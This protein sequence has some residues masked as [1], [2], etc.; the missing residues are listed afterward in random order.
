MNTLRGTMLLFQCVVSITLLSAISSRAHAAQIT[1]DALA[2]SCQELI[3]I[4]DK[5][6]DQRFIAGMST[7]VA[8]AM[9]AGICRGM[10]EEHTNHSRC[11]RGWYAMAST[12]AES[13]SYS[14]VEVMLE[15]ACGN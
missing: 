7:S 13:D 12:I 15:I 5:K 10:I 4:Y 2:T 3:A 9:R 8:E 1:A 14:D 11:N 6:G